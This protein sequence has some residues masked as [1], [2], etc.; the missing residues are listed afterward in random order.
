[1]DISDLTVPWIDSPFFEKL[2]AKSDL[3]E[4]TLN[5]VRTFARDGVLILEPQTQNFDELADRIIGGCSKRPDYP[6][7]RLK[8]WEDA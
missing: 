8:G 6:A 2:T 5:M 4:T 1:M 3:D 7:C